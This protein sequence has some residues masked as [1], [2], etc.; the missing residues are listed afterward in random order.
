[1]FYIHCSP[2]WQRMAQDPSCSR[3]HQTW[4]V[5]WGCDLKFGFLPFIYSINVTHILTGLTWSCL[6]CFSVFPLLG[7]KASFMTNQGPYLPS[8]SIQYF[9][10]QILWSETTHTCL[11]YMELYPHDI[12][13]YLKLLNKRQEWVLYIKTKQISLKHKLG[14]VWFWSLIERVHST[15]NT[16]P[17]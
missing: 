17:M 9:T 5:T 11:F 8:K 2:D 10:E 7:C 3:Q 13:V 14:N 16:L 15:I 12:P 6:V 1:M 4:L